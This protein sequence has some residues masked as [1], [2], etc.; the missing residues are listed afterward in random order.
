VTRAKNQ[1]KADIAIATESEG[2]F[3]EEVGLQCLLTGS[4]SNPADI[5]ALIDSI[6]SAELNA[7]VKKG[8]LSMASYGNIANV[9]HLD[10]LKK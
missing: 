8:K 9:P 7:I 4:I 10:Q 5:D 3:I 6:T 1:L 2:G